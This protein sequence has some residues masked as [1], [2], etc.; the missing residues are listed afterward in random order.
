MKR[1]IRFRGKDVFS[2]KWVYGDLAHN[3]KITREGL[4][5]RVMVAGYEVDPA[6]VGQFTG[7]HDKNGTEIYEDDVLMSCCGFPRIETVVFVRYKDGVFI[8]T[9]WERNFGYL[10]HLLDS[11]LTVIG[12]IHS[13][14]IFIDKIKQVCNEKRTD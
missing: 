10:S 2:G 5:P 6:T 14:D 7:L 12:N 1:E 8:L 13:S 3:Q 4:E 11:E 9:N